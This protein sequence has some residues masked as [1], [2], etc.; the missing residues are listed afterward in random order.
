MQLK[1]RVVITSPVRDVVSVWALPR[2]F[3]VQAFAK[4]IDGLFE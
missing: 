3:A 1:D 4:L 2:H